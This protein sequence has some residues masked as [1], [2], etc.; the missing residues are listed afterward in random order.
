MSVEPKLNSRSHMVLSAVD[1]AEHDVDAADAG[2]QVGDHAALGDLRQRLQVGER[3]LA[4]LDAIGVRSAVRDHVVAHLAARG[5]D[6]LIDLTYWNTKAFR[7]NLK[8]I[9]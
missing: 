9:D 5:F 6:R 3:G 8:V 4:D 1:F 2:H 7:N